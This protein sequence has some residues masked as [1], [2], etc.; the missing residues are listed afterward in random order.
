VVGGR[1]RGAA[2][3]RLAEHGP[4]G[5]R[6]RRRRGRRADGLESKRRRG[7]ASRPGGAGLRGRHG[8]GDRR[9]PAV[10][11]PGGRAVVAWTKEGALQT[12]AADGSG[13]FGPVQ[14]VTLPPAP[15]GG[16]PYVDG[17]HLAAT[18]TGRVVFATHTLLDPNGGR[19]AGARVDAF[20]WAPG[21]PAPGPVSTISQALFSGSPA[22]LARAETVFVAWTETAASDQ[23]P[24]TMRVARFGPGG[25][26][27]TTTYTNSDHNLGYVSGTPVLQAL[28][29]TA[30]RVYYRPSR[31]ARA[32]T[33]TFD[34]T[35]RA[36]GASLVAE[37][38]NADLAG[39]LARDGSLLAW[40]RQLGTGNA[41][42][43][44]QIATP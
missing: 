40:T 5:P 16:N 37:R 36:R 19:G 10:L 7:R 18:P 21:A 11:G 31:S 25:V 30:V 24:H 8:A 38:T 32:Y 4:A 13:A 6:R 12:A 29:G 34:E 43:R 14:T 35:G 15:G 41:A 3:D 26:T 27:P 17:V 2:D 44:V 1:G 39:A 9:R 42:Y 23:G 22:V 28:P 20:D 33:V